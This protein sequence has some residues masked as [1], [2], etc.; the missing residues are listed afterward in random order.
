MAIAIASRKARTTPN[1][2]RANEVNRFRLFA[3]ALVWLACAA[4]LPAE[5]FRTDSLP[6]YD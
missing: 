3:A 2:R 6:L 5:Q 4:G 1:D